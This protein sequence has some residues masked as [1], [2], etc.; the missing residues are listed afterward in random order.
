MDVIPGDCE[1]AL[2]LC[3][4]SD[5]GSVRAWKLELGEGFRE[6]STY[7]EH[8]VHREQAREVSERKSQS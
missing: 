3:T 1:G 6:P 7:K 4:T 8:E 2:S 5:D